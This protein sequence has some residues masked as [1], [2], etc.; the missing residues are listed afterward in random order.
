MKYC[1]KCGSQVSQDAVVCTKC[2]CAINGSINEKNEVKKNYDSAAL[3]T[4]AGIILLA[5]GAFNFVIT[6][7][8][9][10]FEVAEH[11]FSSFDNFF[12]YGPWMYLQSPLMAIVLGYFVME[13]SK[14][15]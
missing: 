12:K 15:K 8:D 7:F 1:S 10:F 4:I 11:A 9:W 14:K 13:H 6:L 5:V 3:L 2:G